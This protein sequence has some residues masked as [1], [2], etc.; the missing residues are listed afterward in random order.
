M[1]GLVNNAM[2]AAFMN[3]V[4][5]VKNVKVLMHDNILLGNAAGHTMVQDG[6]QALD[7][8]MAAA[9]GK[10]PVEQLIGDLLSD[11]LTP[12]QLHELEL[13]ESKVDT[14]VK[15]GKVFPTMQEKMNER[16]AELSNG[17]LDVEKIDKQIHAVLD[18]AHK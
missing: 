13:W 7:I 9:E 15:F 8:V 11:D 12:D 1:L 14:A 4:V 2:Q 5:S 6:E 16:I 17:K 3:A 18:H 10:A